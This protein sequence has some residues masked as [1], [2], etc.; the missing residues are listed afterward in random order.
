L[1]RT[2]DIFVN[3]EVEKMK[4]SESIQLVKQ[5]TPLDIREVIQTIGDTDT[6]QF[7]YIGMIFYVVDAN[8]YYKVTS[9]K[10]GYQGS[11][12]ICRVNKQQITDRI[13]TNCLI[14]GFEDYITT[15]GTGNVDLTGYVREEQLDN[16]AE[17][18][19]THFDYVTTDFAQQ[20]LALKYELSDYAELYHTHVEYM[21]EDEVLNIV[22]NN[23]PSIDTS[24]LVTKEEL[25]NIDAYNF[26]TINIGTPYDSDIIQTVRDKWVEYV[27]EGIT[28][29]DGLFY[30]RN[31]NPETIIRVN[32]ADGIIYVN[33]DYDTPDTFNIY[34][35]YS[36]NKYSITQPEGTEFNDWET[37]S[38]LYPPL[39]ATVSIQEITAIDTFI[40]PGLRGSSS[41]GSTSNV[42]ATIKKIP[43]VDTSNLVTKGELNIYTTEEEVLNIVQN[44][45]PS[46]DT[47]NLVTKSELSGYS[48]TDHTHDYAKIYRCTQDEYIAI[49]NKDP[50]T[51][52]III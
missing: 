44:N 21:T 38:C 25:N 47:S 26:F 23:T 7:P 1:E 46:V 19:H 34:K 4:V 10:N 48:T 14:G 32:S 39:N 30:D 50:N 24:N 9:L 28:L 11:D 16:Y 3:K 49:I 45:A 13:I 36:T 27:H 15:G 12:G 41:Q 6:I 18:D 5:N 51:L 31:F 22:Q 40:N 29:N 17:K 43:T 2:V 20:N 8:K 33:L 37:I 42:F 52:Y 35:I